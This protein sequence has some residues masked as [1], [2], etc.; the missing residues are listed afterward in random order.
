VPRPAF[1]RGTMRAWAEFCLAFPW[2][3]ELAAGRPG[4]KGLRDAPGWG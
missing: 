2:V 4:I 1:L 3:G